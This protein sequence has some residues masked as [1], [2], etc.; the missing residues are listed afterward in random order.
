MCATTDFP[1]GPAEMREYDTNN[2]KI[3]DDLFMNG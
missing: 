3:N 2:L 1:D